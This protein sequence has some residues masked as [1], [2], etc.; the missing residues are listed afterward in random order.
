VAGDVSK[1]AHPTA[2]DTLA[3]EPVASSSSSV[4]ATSNTV[5]VVEHVEADPKVPRFAAACVEGERVRVNAVGDVLLHQ[6]LQR[7][8]YADPRG[9]RALWAEVEDLLADAELTLANLES[10]LAP[11]L[12]RD[13]SEVEDPGRRYDNVVYT[14][15]PSFNVHPLLAR[16]LVEGGVDLVTTAN[17][18]ALD[19]GPEGIDRTIRELRRAK[20]P[21]VG[22]RTQAD[23]R[24]E[25]TTTWST[26]AQAGP[27]RVAVV[28]CTEWVNQKPDPLHQVLRCK[29]DRAWI[30]REVRRLAARDDVDVVA[31]APHWGKEYAAGP[32]TWQ[33]EWAQRMV[34]AGA[35]LVLGGHP[36]VL[37]PWER[38]TAKDGREAGVVWSLGNFA[39]HQQ[40]LP[41]RSEAIVQVGLV[42]DAEGRSHVAAFAAHPIHQAREDEQFF[43][44]SIV[45]DR[46]PQD[47]WEHVRSVLGHA[48]E[49]APQQAWW[50]VTPCTAATP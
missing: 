42:R 24:A 23:A 17:N 26:I 50:D 22:T 19:R 18:H 5:A 36:H 43:V 8:A 45:R 21:F 29:T 12:A 32:A 27:L 33:R 46:G 47:A 39:S 3:S 49:L 1:T 38:L 9:A 6:E 15:Y 31:V 10:P 44:R 16:G 35:S 40:D 7:T 2:N 48:A 13:G 28:A 34:D 30:E 25:R 41:K 11:G 20:L 14:A 37:Q 4:P